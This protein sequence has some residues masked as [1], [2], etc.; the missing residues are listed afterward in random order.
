MA[1]IDASIARVPYYLYDEDHQGIRHNH[2][3]GVG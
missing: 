1:F 2:K 3:E